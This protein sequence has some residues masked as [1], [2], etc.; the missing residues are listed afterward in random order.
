[1][2]LV[3]RTETE[4]ARCVA[5]ADS[6][7]SRVGHVAAQLGVVTPI[8][9]PRAAQLGVVTPILGPRAAQLGVVTPVLGPRAAQL[10]VVAP[11]LGPRAA[12]LGFLVRL[13]GPRAF[14]FARASVTG[15]PGWAAILF[16]ERCRV[17]GILRRP[18]L[19]R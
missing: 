11:V 5:G 13:L 18:Q 12:Q 15:I 19:E 17:A 7:G 6:V 3:G 9:G 10:G 16:V 14:F 1:M 8:L 4:L 2:E